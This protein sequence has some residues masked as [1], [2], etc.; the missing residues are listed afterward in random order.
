MIGCAQIEKYIDPGNLVFFVQIGD[1]LVPN[2]LI[3]LEVAINVMTKKTMGQLQFTHIHPTPTALELVNRSKIKSKSMLDDVVVSTDA[4]EYP[5]Y[6]IVLQPK[7]P[8]RG[9][10][11]I[12][13]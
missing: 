5:A 1:V 6:F 8:I 12:L 2:V 7:N 11:L 13:G 10:P 9:H 3:Y 4:W